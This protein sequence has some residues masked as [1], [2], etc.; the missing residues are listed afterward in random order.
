MDVE[1]L[2]VSKLFDPARFLNQF[3]AKIDVLCSLPCAGDA[4]NVTEMTS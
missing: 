2:T 3:T 1:V 4:K